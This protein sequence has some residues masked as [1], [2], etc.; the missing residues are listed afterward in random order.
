M[1]TNTKAFGLVRLLP[2]VALFATTSIVAN[3]QAIGK[4]S[5]VKPQAEANGRTLSPG[6]DM[7][8]QETVR[9]GASGV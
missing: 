9:T 6:G 4:V 2:L 5:S 8:S 3:A 7:F 1:N